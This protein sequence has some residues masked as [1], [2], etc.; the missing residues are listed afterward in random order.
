MPNLRL[1]RRHLDGCVAGYK[2]AI[3]T[4]ESDEMRPK[5]PK[6]RCTIYAGGTLGGKFRRHSTGKWRWE[7]AKAVAAAW[8]AA[9]QWEG[10]APPPTIPGSAD[11]ADRVTIERAIKDFLEE[12]ER[13]SSRNTVKRYERPLDNL[14]RYCAE[15]GFVMLDQLGPVE[16]R[17]FRSLW[18]VGPSTARTEMSVIRGFF[19][20]CL[21]NEWIDR[22]PGKLVKNPK[23]RSNADPRNEQKLPYTDGE[24]KRMYDVA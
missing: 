14:K 13:N 2:D 12:H 24:L 22:N 16:L 23:G 11:K 4:Y 8:E 19:E 21:C 17:E 18:T 1:Y 10:V 5:A 9:G 15:K 7:E 6:C 20:F 3:Q